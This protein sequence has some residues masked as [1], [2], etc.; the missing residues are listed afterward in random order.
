MSIELESES[1]YLFA[2]RTRS[3][4]A[5]GTRT[6]VTTVA[7]DFASVSSTFI[8][9][10]ACLFARPHHATAITFLRFI[11]THALLLALLGA[12]GAFCVAWLIACMYAAGKQF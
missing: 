1:N 6:A 3:Q 11:A 10:I 4:L 8:R 5:G 7:F 9:F 2:A 12:W